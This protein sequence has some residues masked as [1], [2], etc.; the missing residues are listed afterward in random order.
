MIYKYGDNNSHDSNNRS[1][2]FDEER[3][4]PLSNANATA[5]NNNNV[6]VS[7][8]RSVIGLRGVSAHAYGN[9]HDSASV[10]GDV[11]DGIVERDER[12]DGADASALMSV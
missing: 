3:R 1:L 2:P 6:F 5:Q 12:G 10:N 4:R 8:D 9:Y 7:N 11:F